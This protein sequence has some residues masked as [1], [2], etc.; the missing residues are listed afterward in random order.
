MPVQETSTR[1]LEVSPTPS[2]A[3]SNIG[4]SATRWLTSEAAVLSCILAVTA[5]VYLRCLA[6]GFVL[7][8]GAQIVKNPNFGD[9][10]FLWK[11]FTREE[12]WYSDAGFLPH[13]RN[14]RPLILVW[15][16]ADYH[17]FGLNPAPWHA[18]VV[19]VHLLAVWLVFKVCRR[20]AD[21][22]TSALLAAAA[23]ALTPVHVAAVV[24]MA[25]SGFVFAT[26]F[27]LAAFYLIM[28]R[29]A[30]TARN[31][32]IAIAF[33]ACALL[34]HESAIAFPGLVACYAFIF[35]EANRASLWMGA[36]RAVIWSAPFA[37]ELMLYMVTRRLVLGFFVSNPYDIINLLTGAQIILTVPLV[38]GTYLT[39]L[40]LPW[41]TLPNHRVL[42]V[43]SL[44]SPEFWAP[45]AAIVM[46]AAGFLIIA[47]RSPRRRLYL[48]CGAWI[49]ITLAPMMLLHS[50]YHLV[51]DYYLY[52]P[53]VG[54][55]IL[56]G[57]VIA[58]VAR[59]N[60][61]AR[62]LAFGGAVA[63]LI[64][65]AV[66]LWRV[67]RFWH[68]DI[69]AAR[70]YIEGSP[71]S[72]AWHTTLATYL[73]QKGDL[74]GAESEALKALSFEPDQTGTIRPSYKELHGL[75]G[76]LMA[77][78]GDIDGAEAEFRQSAS[79]PASEDEDNAHIPAARRAY[80][81][82]AYTLYNKGLRDQESGR[83]DQAA[84]EINEAIERMK[85]VPAAE[86][87]PIA[88]RYVPLVVLYDAKGDQAQVDSLL[89]RLD[90]MPEGEL[91]VGLAQAKIR[92]Q[93]SDKAGAA[94]ILSELSHR[95]QQTPEVLIRLGDVQADLNQNEQALASYQRANES[96][97]GDPQLHVAMAK[98]LHA[99][100]R[101]RE[102]LDQCRLAQAMAPHD[103][104]A[105]FACLQIKNETENK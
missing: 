34:S 28:P 64:V 95:F 2:Y 44:L 78:R 55:C 69:A 104:Q 12:F 37:I 53:S 77:M 101:D 20:L 36:R 30:D 97:I 6:N 88:L 103:W 93:H 67:E 21:D 65:Y 8:D 61:L 7:D 14:Y 58:V 4:L 42:P 102:A 75:I 76:E 32:A 25:A 105:Q 62:R 84:A 96:A 10:S 3:P 91:A 56:V 57:D 18:S 23:F 41:L 68:D 35:D 5:L 82:D 22:S 83:L 1:S 100:G 72:V 51:Q 87:G 19:L 98:S 24:W 85:R 94:R 31:W 86:F 73:E 33:Y 79:D 40:A 60:A 46:M 43:S 89:K 47:V 99:M 90:S 52:L 59:Q 27:V 26:A 92:L 63:V 17:L 81:K 49:G 13:Y 45:L 11:A 16:W 54:W 48:F 39:D 29:A 9:W 50:V 15:Y 38:L 70:G 71:E 74:A 80:I 66:A